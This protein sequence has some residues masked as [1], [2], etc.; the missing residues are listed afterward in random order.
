MGANKPKTVLAIMASLLQ[1]EK[2]CSNKQN[3]LCSN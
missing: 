2:E 3:D 1:W